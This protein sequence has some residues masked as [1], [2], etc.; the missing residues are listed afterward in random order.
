VIGS[1]AS[2]TSTTKLPHETDTNIGALHACSGTARLLSRVLVCF[3]R[4]FAYG[5]RPDLR[6]GI[7]RPLL[8]AA[9]ARI[10]SGALYASAVLEELEARFEHCAR[11]SGVPG[12]SWAL[13]NDGEIA[14]AGAFGVQVASGSCPV[15]N[16]T[17]F[18][19]AWPERGGNTA[20]GSRDDR[21]LDR[22]SSETAS[23]NG[24]SAP[25]IYDGGE[26]R[27]APRARSILWLR[28]GEK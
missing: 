10:R 20:L 15:T 25:L 4:P 3:T 6:P 21:R 8:T 27:P 12:I 19:R 16:T 13:I 14:H 9:S 28:S 18:Q 7:E 23:P 26:P 1:A 24:A 11:A 17:T 22:L 2:S 5:D